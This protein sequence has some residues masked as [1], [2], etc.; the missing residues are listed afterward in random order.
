[1][2]RCK[3]RCRTRA[4]QPTRRTNSTVARLQF[5][6]SPAQ[7]NS[8]V[9]TVSGGSLGFVGADWEQGEFRGIEIELQP[10]DAASCRCAQVQTVLQVSAD[11]DKC[12]SGSNATTCPVAVLLGTLPQF[13]TLL[14]SAVASLNLWALESPRLR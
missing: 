4:Y 8:Q 2:N 3:L 5:R 14:P 6:D 1:M 7:S 11:I 13:P 12:V 10:L 9:K